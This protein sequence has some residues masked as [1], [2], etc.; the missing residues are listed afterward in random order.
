MWKKTLAV[1]F[2]ALLPVFPKAAFAGQWNLVGED[3]WEYQNDDGS[4]LRDG[5]TPEG[6][7]INGTGV[8]HPYVDILGTRLFARNNFLSS[9]RMG[10][11]T[12]LEMMLSGTQALMAKNLGKEARGFY[13]YKNHV[14]CCQAGNKDSPLL[15]L[16]PDSVFEGGGYQVIVNTPLSSSPWGSSL[17]AWYDYQCLRIYLNLFSRTGDQLAE[18][19]CDS[20]SGGNVYGLKAG[21]WIAVGD[22]QICYEP[23]DGNGVYRIREAY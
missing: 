13:L 19:I 10:D 8:W 5:F 20:W 22:S 1:L 2:L 16:Y 17:P 12:R 7:F 14:D 18:A 11:M 4:I 21:Q 15:S 23:A 3:A 9:D 6:Y